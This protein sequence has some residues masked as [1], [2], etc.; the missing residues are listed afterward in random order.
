M[1]TSESDLPDTSEVHRIAEIVRN[2]CLDAARDG[3]F[4]A[5]MSGLCHEGA[6]ENALGAIQSLDLDLV[7]REA[8]SAEEAR[9]L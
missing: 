3:Y 5:G 6:W 9:R 1:H 2:A 8:L 4:Q 7:L